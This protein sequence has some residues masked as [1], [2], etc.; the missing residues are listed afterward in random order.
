MSFADQITAIIVT[1]PIWCNPS[2]AIIDET[3][4]QLRYHLGTDV[5]ILILMDGTHPEETYLYDRYNGFMKTLEARDW[6]NVECVRFSQWRHQSGMLRQVLI[7][8]E[9]VTTPLVFWTEHDIP[10]CD[11]RID[12]NGLVASLVDGE[13]GGIRFELNGDGNDSQSR[14][15]HINDHGVPIRRTFQFLGWPHL[16]R[17]VALKRFIET[18]GNAK[19]YLE[20]GDFEGF[21]SRNYE[22][23]PYGVY[24]PPE[25]AIRC[26]HTNG[27]E[28]NIPGQKKTLKP[29]VEI[30]GHHRYPSNGKPYIRIPEL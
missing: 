30:D 3:Y 24:N 26:Y 18:Y 2:T 19:T 23:F 12:W 5:R 22:E 9:L 13:Y 25:D 27:R 14:G 7:E 6:D 16:F 20:T 21:W 28:R 11:K 29:Y 17:T 10:L 4:Y 15:E 1:S 8:Q